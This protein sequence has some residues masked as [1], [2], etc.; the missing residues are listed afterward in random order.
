MAKSQQAAG[1][2]FGPQPPTP[3]LNPYKLAHIKRATEIA[4]IFDGSVTANN[5]TWLA[6]VDAYG[7]DNDG[8]E[9]RTYM[10]DNYGLSSNT[11]P[12]ENQGLPISI[13]GGNE[14]EPLPQL[15]IT[16]RIRRITGAT[17]V[18]DTAAIIRPT[19]SWSTDTFKP[20]I[21][22]R[23]TRRRTCLKAISM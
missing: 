4:M 12:V 21:T 13:I 9:T 17:F 15:K 10:T 11:A 1:G 23:T 18:S 16:T 8:I 5:G 19:R 22:T 2:K 3:Y 7:L 6:S 20:S 14:T